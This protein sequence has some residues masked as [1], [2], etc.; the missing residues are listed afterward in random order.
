[1]GDSSE[2]HGLFVDV[3]ARKL[4]AL[5]LE[6]VKAQEAVITQK[7]V[8]TEKAMQ[9]KRTEKTFERLKETIYREQEKKDL[10]AILEAMTQ[11]IGTSLP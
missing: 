10:A 8:T 3:K 9:V 11:R 1:M 6:E 5:A 7:A 2:L 4:K